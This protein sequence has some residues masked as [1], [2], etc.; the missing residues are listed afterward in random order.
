MTTK[1][2]I[3][4]GY[5]FALSIKTGHGVAFFEWLAHSNVDSAQIDPH[6]NV[7]VTR[8]DGGDWSITATSLA[9]AVGTWPLGTPIVPVIEWLDDAFGVKTAD[10]GDISS[11]LDKLRDAR[12]RAADAKA[13]ADELRAEVL[14][15]LTV[16]RATIG[17]VGGVPVIGIKTIPQAGRFDRKAFEAEYPT[18]A[19]RFTAPDTEQKRLEFL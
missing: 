12:K 13:E 16:R 7:V 5:D 17:T 4:G 2:T 3:P 11:R 18:I 10:L 8:N 14:A 9:G 6:Q 15:I 1:Y 19:A